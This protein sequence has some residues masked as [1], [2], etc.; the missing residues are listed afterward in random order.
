MSLY[1]RIRVTENPYSRIFYAMK[2]TKDFSE[3]SSE[4]IVISNKLIISIKESHR[5]YQD[6]LKRQRI[7]ELQ[8]SLKRKIVADEIKALKERYFKL[9][10]E[11]KMLCVDAFL[12]KQEGFMTFVIPNNQTKIK[13]LLITRCRTK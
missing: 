7:Q 12:L 9:V 10:S 13:N 5:L 6:E 8:K 3:L 2:I 11:I 1:E 4:T